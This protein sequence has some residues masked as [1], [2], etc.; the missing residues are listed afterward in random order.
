MVKDNQVSLKNNY[1]NR[2]NDF[3]LFNSDAN[4]SRGQIVWRKV[5]GLEN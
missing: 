5:S 3:L 1:D 2:L 4:R